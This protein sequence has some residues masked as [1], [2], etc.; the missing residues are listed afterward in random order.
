VL[1]VP[2]YRMA[3]RDGPGLEVMRE[4]WDACGVDAVV[5]GSSAMVEEYSLAIGFPPANAALI[6]W[7]SECGASIRRMLGREPVVMPSP[8]LDCLISSL[9]K[10]RNS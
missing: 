1:V 8:N 7:G 5:F 10:I 9:I 4:Q 2:T 6:A 3:K